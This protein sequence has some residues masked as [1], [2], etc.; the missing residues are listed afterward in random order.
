MSN[1]APMNNVRAAAPKRVPLARKFALLC[2][3]VCLIAFGGGG[4]LVH[5]MSEHALRKEIVGRAAAEAETYATALG[6]ELRLF[7]RRMEDFASDGYV[8]DRLARADDP[9]ARK[10]LEDHLVR[11]KLPLVPAFLGLAANDAEGR[12]VALVGRAAEYGDAVRTAVGEAVAVYG[13]VTTDGNGAGRLALPVVVPVFTLDGSRRIGRLTAWVRPRLWIAGALKDAYGR[14][15]HAT[16]LKV[17]LVAPDQA[18]YILSSTIL[19][20]EGRSADAADPEVLRPGSV[21]DDRAEGFVFVERP[22]ADTRWIVRVGRDT[23]TAMDSIE[24]LQVRFFGVGAALTLVAGLLYWLPRRF[25]AGPLSRL[26]DAARRIEDGDLGARAPV[27][28]NDEIG[29]MAASFNTMADAVADR[30]AALETATDDLRREQSRLAAV[31]ASMQEGLL[32]L[33]GDGRPVMANDAALPLVRW[34]SSGHALVPSPGVARNRSDVAGDLGAG[35]A[36]PRNAEIVDAA[37]RIYEMTTAA[38]GA[39]GTANAGV[40]VVARDVTSR[41]ADEER[42]THQERLAVLGEVAAVMAHELNN[43]LAAICLFNGMLEDGLPPDSGLQKHVSVIRRNAD[44][45]KQSIRTLLD[46]ATGSAPTVAPVDLHT[47]IHDIARFLGPVAERAGAQ[48]AV[49]AAAADPIVVGDETQCRQILINL[50]MNA[51]QASE[52]RPTAVR[53]ATRDGTDAVL[54]DVADDGPGVPPEIRQEI[55]RPFFTTKPRGQGTGLGLSTAR[56]IAELQGGGLELI[57]SA[58]KGATFRIRLA[59]GRK[60]A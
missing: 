39:A 8:R 35:T 9:A 46:Y 47:V 33:D 24:L 14:P 20:G 41:V 11:N 26:R 52:G 12:S 49:D 38:I 30:A 23:T 40:V 3:G 51:I 6:A 34:M 15:Q 29:E 31:I 56:R 28:T 48:I 42:Q 17:G 2:G 60:I 1:D 25:V 19:G 36:L 45:C 57:E 53:I 37:G 13:P 54:I 32:V 22:V 18:D 4:Y 7:G 5:R 50:V 59:R 16:G 21:A 27:E 10:E 43:P 44:V 58:A 55:F